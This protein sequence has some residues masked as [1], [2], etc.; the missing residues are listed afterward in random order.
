MWL[1]NHDHIF[2]RPNLASD[3]EAIAAQKIIIAL[4]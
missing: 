1:V 3:K 2:L 4:T